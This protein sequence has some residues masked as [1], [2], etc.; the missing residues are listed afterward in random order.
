M[1]DW[2]GAMIR[3]QYNS[4]WQSWFPVRIKMEQDGNHKEISWDDIPNTFSGLV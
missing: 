2:E 4:G 3:F 1:S